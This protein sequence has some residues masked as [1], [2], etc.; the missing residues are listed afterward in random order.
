MSQSTS[1]QSDSSHSQ[2]KENEAP[3]LPAPE[4]VGYKQLAL[5]EGFPPPAEK[6]VTRG[7]YLIKY[8]KLRWAFQHMREL[9]PS[10]QIRR[11][12]GPVS[13]LPVGDNRQQEIDAIR[14][15]LADGSSMTFAQFLQSNYTDACIIVHRGKVIYE[16]Y[17]NQPDPLNL[18]MLWSVT[19]SVTGLVACMLIEEGVIDPQALV[20]DLVPELA[21]SGWANATVQQ[22]LDMTADVNYSEIYSEGT[23]DVIRYGLSA[24]ITQSTK[25]P[26]PACLYDYLPTIG[27]AREHGQFFSY[28]TVHTEVLG[29]L[30]RRAS[31]KEMAAHITERIWSKLGAEED[32]LILLDAHGTE[33]AG[34]GLNASLRDLARLTE[35][36][37]N[38]GR[39]NGQQIIP[40]S[41]VKEIGK[42]AD[43]AAFADYGRVGMDGY[44]Y[45]NQWWVTHNA[46]G[47]YEAMGVHGQLLHINPAAE[48]TVVRTA[49]HPVASNDFTYE[50]TRIA[51]EALATHLRE[52]DQVK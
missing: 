36:L 29:W 44:S 1:S 47:V 38:N 12:T 35:M 41:I 34:A 5:M 30:I 21:E 8:P 3:N 27:G 7:D 25:H 16:T 50:T 52:E 39:W 9:I 20:T 51:L 45:H 23:S 4:T 19:K 10:R 17:P 18:H 33:W 13:E 14:F 11:G 15:D 2:A 31:G 26:A 40:E 24:G 6:L 46:D 48:L 32:A 43:K 37:R 42:G 49:S 28:R 22:V